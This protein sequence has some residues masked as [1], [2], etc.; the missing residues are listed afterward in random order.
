MSG[1]NGDELKNKIDLLRDKIN[2]IKS[3][4]SKSELLIKEYPPGK[5]TIPEL[6]SYLDNIKKKGYAFD[7]VFLDYITLLKSS[8]D[9]GLYEKGKQLSEDLRALSYKH[10]VSFVTVIQANRSG[11]KEGQPKLDN[12][13]ESMGIA[14]TADFIA[15]IWRE[16]E[17]VE[18]NTLR[19][20]VLKNRIGKN[21]GVQVLEMSD[22]NLKLCEVD[23]IYEN[24]KVEMEKSLK[25]Q[26]ESLSSLC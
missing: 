2:N 10:G 25:E 13:S 15:S 18:T 1:I 20:G 26:L 7:I 6:D 8:V 14:H 19:I 11:S 4:N 24:D 12:T 5:L 23:E 16:E 22:V 17:D 9:S 3:I 21:Y